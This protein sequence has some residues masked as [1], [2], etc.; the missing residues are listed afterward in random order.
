MS[1]VMMTPLGVNPETCKECGEWIGASSALRSSTRG[2]CRTTRE[3]HL[4][5]EALVKYG[6]HDDMLDVGDVDL[7]GAVDRAFDMAKAG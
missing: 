7:Q 1:S 6:N 2:H 5:R 4:L 3:L